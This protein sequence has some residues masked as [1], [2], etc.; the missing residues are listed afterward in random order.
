MRHNIL[1]LI[2]SSGFFGAENVLLELSTELKKLG[3]SVTIGL[4]NNASNLDSDLKKK[5]EERSLPLRIFQCRGKFDLKTVS[6]IASFV[7]ENS[8]DIIHSHGYKSNAYAILSNRTNKKPL[9]TTCHNWINLSLK[10]SFYTKIDKFILKRFDSVASVS[11]TVRQ[12]LIMSGI[13]PEKIILIENGI[14]VSRFAD[15][16]RDPQLRKKFSIGDSSKV[17]G[18]VGRLTEEKGHSFFLKMAKEL[19]IKHEDC[20]FLIVGDGP[21]RLKL[22]EEANRLGIAGK[23][24]FAGK[25]DNI[26]AM[27]SIMDVFVLPSLTE[28]Q[29]MAL[30]EAMAA[31]KAIVATDVGDVAKILK[32]GKLGYTVPS[33]DLDAIV[34]AAFILLTAQDKTKPMCTMAHAEVLKNYSSTRMAR[35]YIKVY[36]SL[37]KE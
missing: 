19:L 33:G 10:M 6:E 31:G 16:K 7:R 29:P 34:D 26:P 3:H 9:V 17:I 25:Q 23:V 36:N 4:F 15:C 20:H 8:T 2:S 30:F 24:I 32:N 21:L 13:A 12:A 27:L 11:E 1:Q 28:G 35:D 22:Q 18:T 37:H 14:N 5:A